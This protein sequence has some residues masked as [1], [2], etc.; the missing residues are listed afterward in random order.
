MIKKEVSFLLI[1]PTW[2]AVVIGVMHM[3]LRTL[4]LN[5]IE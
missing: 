4:T 5:D 1:P 2:I 3:T